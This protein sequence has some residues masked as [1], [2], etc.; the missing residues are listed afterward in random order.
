MHLDPLK[1]CTIYVLSKRLKGTF[2]KKCLVVFS[3]RHIILYKI[4][5]SKFLH[6]LQ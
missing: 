5:K 4:L 3:E 6:S 2:M 1:L